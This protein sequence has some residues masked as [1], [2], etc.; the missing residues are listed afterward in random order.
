MVLGSLLNKSMHVCGRGLIVLS[1]EHGFV[2][3]C[4]SCPALLVTGQTQL[5]ACNQIKKIGTGKEK[6]HCA[7]RWSAYPVTQSYSIWTTE[8]FPPDSCLVRKWAEMPCHST[9]PENCLSTWKQQLTW[10]QKPRVVASS[11]VL[12]RRIEQRKY[13]QL[14][15]FFFLTLRHMTE[16]LCRQEVT[17]WRTCLWIAS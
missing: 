3:V 11:F 9:S 17:Q 1:S 15:F 16:V 2:C 12:T 7:G 8:A 4:S 13:T 5:L 14:F 6:C 10:K